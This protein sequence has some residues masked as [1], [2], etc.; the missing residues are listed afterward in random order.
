MLNDQKEKIA[1]EVIKTLY[2]RFNSFPENEINSNRNAPFHEAFLNA[3]T[4][5]LNDIN[6]DAN[7]LITLSSWLHGLNTSLGQSFF[8][9]VSRII[10]YGEKRTFKNIK[11]PQK[12]QSN[13]SEIMTSLK[14]GNSKPDLFKENDKIFSSDN[15]D[16]NLVDIPQ[17]TADLYV[18]TDDTIDAYELKSVR[19][20]SGEMRGEKDK[21]LKGK[22]YLKY[23]NPH[24][25]VNYYLSVPYDPTEKNNETNYDK[26]RYMLYSVEFNKFIDKNE[27]LLASE[28][29][30]HLSGEKGTMEEILNIIRS[31]AT[32][33]FFEKYNYINDTENLGTIQYRNILNEWFLF[34]EMKIIE[35]L[36]KIKETSKE[37]KKLQ[38]NLNNS[39][40][41]DGKLNSNR[42]NYLK[43]FL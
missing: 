32:P 19:P 5:K 26:D 41:S 4:N 27:L 38:K 35:Q 11:I 21:I 42:H 28:F 3:F 37:D 29:W 43:Q 24:K 34:S 30:N 33:L 10:S 36:D 15:N 17:F 12:S 31:I 2:S 9:N 14:N 20:N 7:N 6:V 40:F 8:E 13:I 39:L 23:K 1:L 25:T 16:D 18:E 22:A